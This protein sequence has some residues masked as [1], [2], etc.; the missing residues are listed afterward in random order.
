[1]ARSPRRHHG[2]RA[3]GCQPRAGAVLVVL[4]GILL[5][6]LP[7]PTVLA[8]GDPMLVFAV[9]TS[10]SK[11][12]KEVKGQVYAGGKVMEAVLIPTDPIKNNLA[13]KKLE[14]CHALRAEAWQVPEGFRIASIRI[15]NAGM[16]PMALQGL[17]GDCLLKKALEFAPLVD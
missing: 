5:L 3:T 14:L 2:S 16:L 13:W 9:V 8:Q 6:A 10:L 11:D 15:L 12:G 7:A 17:A 1:M 4:A